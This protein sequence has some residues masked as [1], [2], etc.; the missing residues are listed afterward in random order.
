MPVPKR[1]PSRHSLD[2]R[3][4]QLRATPVARRGF[5]AASLH[6]EEGGRRCRP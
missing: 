3:L 4:A 2:I 1:T 5:A 6:Y